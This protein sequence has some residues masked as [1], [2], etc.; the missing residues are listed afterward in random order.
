[1]HLARYFE[2]IAIITIVTAAPTNNMMS[3]NSFNFIPILSHGDAKVNTRDLTS[4]Q[5]CPSNYNT[6][7]IPGHEGCCPKPL[8]CAITESHPMGECLNWTYKKRDVN[9]QNGKRRHA[10]HSLKVSILS[11]HNQGVD[12]E[13]KF[14]IT[15]SFTFS[16]SPWVTRNSLFNA[17]NNHKRIRWNEIGTLEKCD[18]LFISLSLTRS[19]GSMY[20]ASQRRCLSTCTLLSMSGLTDLLNNLHNNCLGFF[21]WNDSL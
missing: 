7:T 18:W 10:V 2:F 13:I 8:R 4:R 16:I 17:R 11:A 1:M 14:S 12:F 21:G 3:L 9:C 19:F 5:P 20:I 6:C 15:Q